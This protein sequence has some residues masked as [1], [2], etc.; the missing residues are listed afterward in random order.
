[1]NKIKLNL[2]LSSFFLLILLFVFSSVPVL[3]ASAQDTKSPYSFSSKEFKRESPGIKVKA[4]DGWDIY[5]TLSIMKKLSSYSKDEMKKLEEM[6]K[7]LDKKKDAK[8]IKEIEESLKDL[9]EAQKD[10]K[11]VRD[12]KKDIISLFNASPVNV[13]STCI[14]SAKAIKLELLDGIKT[15]GDYLKIVQPLPVPQRNS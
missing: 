4:P 5:P 6:K 9:R 7:R 8:K 14:V 13:K 15:G 12:K 11:T 3:P 10:G 1:M 2:N